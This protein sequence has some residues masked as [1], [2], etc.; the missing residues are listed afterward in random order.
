VTATTVATPSWYDVLD[1]APDA[2]ERDIRAA[3]RSAIAD[4]DPSDRRFRVLNQAAEVLLDRKARKAYDAELQAQPLVEEEAPAPVTKPDATSRR[5]GWVPPGWVLVAL[6]AVTAL[7]VG[8]CAVLAVTEPSD[9][10]VA[11]ATRQAQAGAERAIV[12][13]LSYDASD[14]KGSSRPRRPT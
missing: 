2:S 4:L 10:S 7:V 11:D 8:A 14:M 13:V 12:P 6:G 9:A 1:V 3:W 5:T